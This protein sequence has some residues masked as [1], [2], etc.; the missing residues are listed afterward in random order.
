MRCSIIII[1][2]EDSDR[3][4]FFGVCMNPA[5][6][7]PAAVLRVMN[8]LIE[9]GH[10]AWLVGGCVRDILLTR[11][12]GDWDISTSAHPQTV[13]ALF[14][15]SMETGVLHGTV[16]VLLP[17]GNRNPEMPEV[18]VE[19]K[20]LVLP[21]SKATAHRFPVEVTTWR[22]ESGYSDH[23]HPD[24]VQFSTTLETDLSRRDFTINAMA[25]NPEK[26]LVDLFHGQED[27]AGGLIRCVGD[28]MLRFREDALRMLRAIR[29]CSQLGFRLDADAARAIR[30]HRD[31]LS[32]ISRE[33]TQYEMTRTLMGQSPS[34][35]SLWWETG[36]VLPLF[37]QSGLSPV[38]PGPALIRMEN[39][40]SPDAPMEASLE[41][42]IL[43]WSVF[44][45]ACG[46]SSQIDAVSRWM[47]ENRFP[48]KRTAGIRKL[49]QMEIE[50]AAMTMRNLR[51]TALTEGPEWLGAMLR[52]RWLTVGNPVPDISKLDIPELEMDGNRFMESISPL[53]PPKGAEFGAWVECIR[54]AVCENPACNQSDLLEM[55]AQVIAAS[56]QRHP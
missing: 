50:E 47:R 38:D 43:P 29:F 5:F 33:R 36:I 20:T 10:E 3:I 55:F 52:L 53:A 6:T 9:N 49:L 1:Y 17:T 39:H 35:A 8:R 19:S 54:M 24:K 14:P 44:W 26:G 42:S 37:A 41:A 28:P 21:G 11:Q 34:R 48:R 56:F 32:F 7:P 2:H 30:C 23:R 16:T 18:P 31:A 25:W 51:L 4:F 12:P 15:G 45:T 13:L 27:L 22:S 40:L 46:L